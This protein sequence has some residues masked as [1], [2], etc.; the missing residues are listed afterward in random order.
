MDI[1]MNE[2]KEAQC[3]H[4]GKW[5]NMVHNEKTLLYEI[6]CCSHTYAIFIDKEKLEKF[7]N[8]AKN[9]K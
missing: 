6:S 4:C 8:E 7:V 9:K 1:P 2:K 3:P 5:V